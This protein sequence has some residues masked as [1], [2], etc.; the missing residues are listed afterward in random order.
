MR[1]TSGLHIG[2]V[3]IGRV[4]SYRKEL[5]YLK[6]T[7]NTAQRTQDAC[8]M[9]STSALL[10]KEAI[11]FLDLENTNLYENYQLTKIEGLSL[12]RKSTTVN[13]YVLNRI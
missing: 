2:K 10:S 13:L 5:A 11:N 3:L 12:K 6:D 7:L 9:T 1:H 8:K 4:S